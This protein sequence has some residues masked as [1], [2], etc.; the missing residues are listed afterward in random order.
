MATSKKDKDSANDTGISETKI[1]TWKQMDL[2]KICKVKEICNG[3]ATF[4]I[5]VEFT[6]MSEKMISMKYRSSNV[7]P[8]EAFTDS[9]GAVNLGFRITSQVASQVDL[10]QIADEM[11]G[12]FHALNFK[13]INGEIKRVN[14]RDVIVFQF[15][16]P[17]IDTEIYN[18][19]FATDIDGKLMVGTFNCVIRLKNQWESKAKTMLS[20]LRVE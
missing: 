7:R 18:L 6:K 5:P 17:A 12:Q 1:D 20:S 11:L 19:I 9:K 10:A 14:G 3:R 16:S 4:P 8:T 13:N 2:S 15:I